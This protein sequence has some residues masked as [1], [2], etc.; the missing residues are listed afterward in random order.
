M[1][2]SQKN[3]AVGFSYFFISWF[4]VTTSCFQK[5]IIA[6]TFELLNFTKINY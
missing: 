6:K 1:I 4:S 3:Q 5:V 2:T